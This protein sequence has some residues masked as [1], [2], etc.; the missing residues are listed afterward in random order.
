MAFRCEAMSVYLQRQEKQARCE[1]KA[2]VEI[3]GKK[4][5]LKHAG[6]VAIRLELLNGVAKK[7]PVEVDDI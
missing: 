6:R 5:C 7:L 2:R 3:S 1:H 4:L